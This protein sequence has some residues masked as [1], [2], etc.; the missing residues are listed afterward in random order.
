M[1][2]GPKGIPVEMPHNFISI[3]KDFTA[4]LS[5]SFPEYQYLWDRYQ[6]QGQDSLAS[7]SSY[8]FEELF[9]YCMK[10]YPERFF[11][12]LYQNDEMFLP[13]STINTM[14]L[15]NV[16]FKLFFTLDSVTDS[17]KQ[18]I[19]KYL[20]LILMTIMTSVKNKSTFG[21]SANIFEGIDEE[22]LQNKLNDTISGLGDFFKNMEEKNG[23]EGQEGQT[24]ETNEETQ[25][26]PDFAEDFKKFFSG[27]TEGMPSADDLH[28]HIKGLFG[29]KIGVLAKELAEE[30]SEELMGMMNEDGD[31]TEVKSTQ[32]IFKKIMRNPKKMIDLLKSI[33]G[34]L[35]AKMKAGD[36]SQEE[37]MKEAG[38]LIGK[39]KEMGGGNF[40]EIMKNLTKNMGGLA[41]NKGKMDM[42]ALNRMTAMSSQK[43]RMKAKLDANK[44]KQQQHQ[45]SA[46][47]TD[48]FVL[49]QSATAPNN[50]VF[51]LADGEQ[52][53]KS[54]ISKPIVDND[55]WLNEPM[56]TNPNPN[57]TGSSSK[58]KKSKKGK[59]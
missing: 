14:F 43:E 30:L 18:T 57:A 6:S 47:K 9:S 58:K 50:F 35:N 48:E 17:I 28:S 39:M 19:W 8:V 1:Q 22:E 59:K 38:D 40:G 12:I 23:Q 44:Q 26:T 3:I 5:I 31:K 2:E 56:N 55:D 51:S 49:E 41:G 20:Q 16:E 32:D 36:I 10:I 45:L 42:N 15:P 29:G 24:Q 13:D 34:K 33:S 27:K 37:L 11:D 7:E 21:D 52:Q 25:G 53:P 4:D 46:K 54:S